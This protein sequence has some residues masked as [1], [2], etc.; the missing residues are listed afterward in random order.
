MIFRL[1]REQLLQSTFKF[2]ADKECEQRLV[3]HGEY[4]KREAFQRGILD[5][6][7]LDPNL[8]CQRL[9]EVL[10]DCMIRRTRFSKIDGVLIIPPRPVD[11]KTDF[12]DLTD[13]EREVYDIF[14]YR[15][16]E[17]EEELRCSSLSALK[18]TRGRVFPYRLLC[19]QFCLDPYLVIKQKKRSGRAKWVDEEL[20]QLAEE[21]VEEVSHRDGRMVIILT[22]VTCRPGCSRCFSMLEKV[23]GTVFKD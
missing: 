21:D 1:D 9:Y 19:Q 13:N 17:K 2:G 3:H 15:L 12:I 8:A 5:V 11:H 16:K 10:K 22:N 7:R 14:E 20:V 6:M 4:S 18:E 23:H